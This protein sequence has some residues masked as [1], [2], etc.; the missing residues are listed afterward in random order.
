M[1]IEKVLNVTPEEAKAIKAEINGNTIEEA[2][3]DRSLE[4]KSIY[5]E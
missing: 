1:A 2:N 4:D 3:N 5:G